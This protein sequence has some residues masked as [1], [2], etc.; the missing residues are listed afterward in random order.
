MRNTAA[1]S[2]VSRQADEIV[3]VENPEGTFVAQVKGKPSWEAEGAT[4]SEA[5]DKLLD[6]LETRN[7]AQD[8]PHRHDIAGDPDEVANSTEE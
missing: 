7:E 1:G 6:L 4:A 5:E 8:V 2:K 3:V